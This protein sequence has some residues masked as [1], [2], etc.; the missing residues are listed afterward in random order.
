M[1]LNQH[2]RLRDIS[3]VRTVG[4]AVIPFI[5]LFALYVQFHGDFGPGG[6]FQ[7]GVIFA[8]GFVMYGLIFG[9]QEL[10]KIVNPRVVEVGTALGVMIYGGTG[11]YCLLAGMNF[12]DYDAISPHHPA[13]GQE[14]GIFAVEGGVGIT[15]TSVMVAIYYAFTDRDRSSSESAG[16]Q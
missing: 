6:G 13:H 7:A 16:E 3:I 8:A 12:L 15:V 1:I 5:L 9:P 10:K 4:K 2:T 11:V 14:W